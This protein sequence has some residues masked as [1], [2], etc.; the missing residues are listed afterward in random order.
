MCVNCPY[1]PSFA[2][3]DKLD[4]IFS[5]SLKPIGKDFA[6]VFKSNELIIQFYPNDYKILYRY[7]NENIFCNVNELIT[8]QNIKQYANRFLKLKAFI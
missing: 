7:Y 1:K 5:Q 6:V 2:N 8:A 3:W 4:D